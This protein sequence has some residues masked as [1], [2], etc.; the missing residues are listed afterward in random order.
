MLYAV[1]ALHAQIQKTEKNLLITDLDS[2]NGT[3]ID[4][5]RLQPG[6]VATASPGNLIAFGTKPTSSSIIISKINIAF[7]Q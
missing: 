4:E 2:T 7:Y 5:R 3:F 6:V 1:S